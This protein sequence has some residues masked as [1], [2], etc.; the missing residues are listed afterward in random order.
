M[1][2]YNYESFKKL[3]STREPKKLA[4]WVIAMFIGILLFV[5]FVP[6]TQ[7][8]DGKGY[9]TTLRPEQQPH[10]I[11]SYITGRIE[12]WFV[13]DGQHISKGDTIAYMSEVKTEYISPKMKANLENQFDSKS[14]SL[15]AYK[16][17]LQYLDQNLKA[18]EAEFDLKKQ[19]YQNKIKQYRNKL[20]SDSASFEAI[21]INVGIENIR[22]KR[23]DSLYIIGAKSR[24]EWEESK[25]KLTKAQN[26]IVAYQNKLDI[27]RNE[28][29][30][31]LLESQNYLNEYSAK[32]SKSQSERQ[33]TISDLNNSQKD[34]TEMDN[35]IESIKLRT[36]NHYI[37]APHDS[38]VLRTIKKGIG[39]IVKE[40]EPVV[41]LIPINHDLAVEMYVRPLDLPLI[42]IGEHNRLIFDGWPSLVF[43]GWPNASFGSFGGEVYAIDKNISDNGLYRV[44]IIPDER[45]VAWPELLR[46]GSGVKGVFL[47][48]DVPIWYEMWRQINGFPPEF[49]DGKKSVYKLDE[50]IDSK[51]HTK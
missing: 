33:S 37:I 19:Q 21:K 17:K 39:E 40:G 15:D 42:K 35:K 1:A 13:I 29:F 45:D 10:A 14:L 2:E 38:Y 27:A 43:G 23:T 24:K 32:I 18:L 30:N 44:L 3:E 50:S 12:R 51:Y 9:L 11:N 47:L 34:L 8:V 5:L 26:D 25:L 41:S 36:D 16:L 7:N 31:T 22:F 49:Y 6:W 46:L 4:S 28:L 20:S 48:N